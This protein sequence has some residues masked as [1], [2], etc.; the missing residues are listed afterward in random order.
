M[1]KLYRLVKYEPKRLGFY[2]RILLD[3][4][5]E[6]YVEALEKKREI[7]TCLQNIDRRY[8]IEITTEYIGEEDWDFVI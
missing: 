8:S 3:F 4:N 7:E 1:K 5:M 2:N 6:Y